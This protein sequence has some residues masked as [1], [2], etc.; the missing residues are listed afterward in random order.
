MRQGTVQRE[1]APETRSKIPSPYGSAAVAGVAF[2][3]VALGVVLVWVFGAQAVYAGRIYPGVR[4]LGVPL[5][6]QPVETART[7]LEQR[8]AEM[9]NRAIVIG[10]QELRWTVTGQHL[11]VRPDVNPVLEE[12]FGLGRRG[13]VFSRFVVQWGLLLNGATDEVHAPAYDRPTFSTFMQALTGA[14]ERP[15][16]NASIGVRPEGAVEFTDGLAGRRLMPD[17]TQRRLEAALVDPDVEYVELV[18]E[19]LPPLVSSESLASARERAE[20]LFAEPIVFKFEASEWKLTPEQLATMV[21]VVDGQEVQLSRSAVRAWAVKLAKEVDQAPQEARFTWAGGNLSLLR[22]S[23][24]G[25]DLDVDRT[26]NLI[27]EKAFESDRAIVLPVGV[28]KPSVSQEDGPKLR[29]KGAIE[30]ART[31]F[32]GSSPPKQHNI[33]LAARRLNGVV[34]PPGKIF[35]FNREIGSTSLDAGFRMGWGIAN[36]GKEVKTV[37]SVA[38]GICQV[39]TT[40]FHT[41][42]WGGYQIEE[43]N[44]HLYWIPG[45][46]SKG[47]EGLDATVDEEANLDFR[48]MNNT[49]DYLLVQSWTE[50]AT[51]VFGLYGSKPDWTVKVVPGERTDVVDASKDQV[52]DEEPTLPLGQRLAVEGAMDG[53]KL[54]TVR[55]VRRGSDVRTLR[56]ASTYRPSRNVTLVG[57]GGRPAR[58][59]QVIANQATRAGETPARADGTPVPATPRPAG[60]AAQP[61]TPTGGTGNGVAKP[62]NVPAVPPPTGQ[63]A[64]PPPTAAPASK[65]SGAPQQKPSGTPPRPLFV[66]NAP[67]TPGR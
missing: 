39:A 56:L 30:V 66:P 48:F 29:I 40:L 25:R 55:D 20:R 43:R 9:A 50:G 34:V 41:V 49:E 19:E 42:F 62:V 33:N 59:S 14:V 7:L 37:P 26:T 31:S 18:V 6:G 65:P 21:D 45:Y 4:A 5:G 32:A 46:T 52:I 64:A 61:P 17:A 8:A 51:L 24:D 13:N 67:P 22:E 1:S 23:K 3:A 63:P 35:S 38:G 57:T 11:G 10:H 60:T 44:Y 36:A 28:T 16:R 53:F 2:L 12:A 54:V 47:V 15:V 58:P 27:F